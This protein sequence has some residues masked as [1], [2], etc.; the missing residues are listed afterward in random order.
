MA[1]ISGRVLAVPGANMFPSGMLYVVPMPGSASAGISSAG[2][3]RRTLPRRSAV[4]A[5]VL[6]A[7]QRSGAR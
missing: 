7:S 3:M 6:R 4:F 2:W 1:K 5:A